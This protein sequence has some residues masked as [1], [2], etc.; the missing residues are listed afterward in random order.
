MLR[1][2]VHTFTA[3]VSNILIGRSVPVL[4]AYYLPIEN[5]A[6][7]S[8]PVRILTYATEGVGRIGMVTAPNATELLISGRSEAL[9]DLAV[10]ANRYCFMVFAPVAVFLL[11]YGFPLYSLW[12][13]PDFALKSAYLLPVLLIGEVVVAGQ[14]NSVS[15]LFGMGRHQAYS[16]CLMGEALLTLAL[17]PLV[18]PRFGL[19]GAA[20]VTTALMALDRGAVL[21]WLVS[22]ELGINPWTYAR[23][24]Y[25]LP[26]F[27]GAIVWALVGGL[28]RTI[29][30]GQTWSQLILAGSAG[31][32]AYWLMAFRFCV[33]P[34]HREQ[35]LAKIRSLLPRMR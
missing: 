29:L 22:G 27:F 15:V 19:L 35:A 3:I 32:L 11:H 24:I 10:F 18:L 7:F 25:V 13:R 20:W 9:A 28:K 14:A 8:I 26:A 6:Y 34:Q 23:R 5:L 4:I 31:V 33:A 17:M 1:Y 21:C 12:I 30:P 16:R 2:G